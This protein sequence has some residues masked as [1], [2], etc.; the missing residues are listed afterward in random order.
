MSMAEIRGDRHE[1]A[2]FFIIGL[3]SQEETDQA[4]DIF[5]LRVDLRFWMR[6]RRLCRGRGLRP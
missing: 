6:W 2:E 5:L 4:G 3:C 1:K